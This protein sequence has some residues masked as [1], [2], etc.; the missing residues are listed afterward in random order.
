MR[1]L[2]ARFLAIF[3][4]ALLPVA[5]AAVSVVVS[6]IRH[7][8]EVAVAQVQRWARTV[9]DHQ[10]QL[11]V[12]TELLLTALARNEAVR[13]GGRAECEALLRALRDLHTQYANI[14]V[15]DSTGK[16][17]CSAQPAGYVD[18][19]DRPYYR[20]AMASQ[21]MAGGDYQVGRITRARTL[22]YGYPVTD[23][24]GRV[25]RVVYAAINLDWLSNWTLR[26]SVPPGTALVLADTTG[27]IAYRYPETERYSGMRMDSSVHELLRAGM[28]GG[29]RRARG[30][31]GV[32]R[33][34]ATV[35]VPGP[36]SNFR[37]LVGV[38]ASQAYSLSYQLG[39]R[40]TIFIVILLA[41]VLAIGWMLADQLITKR[42]AVLNAMTQRLAQGDLS[43][44]TGITQGKDELAQLA[45][46]FDSMADALQRSRQDL[47]ELN[48]ELEERVRQRTNEL[49]ALNRE[50]EAFSYSVSHDLRSPLRSMDGF[51]QALLEDYGPQLDD[52]GR[53]YL[54]R[55]RNAAQR[56]GLLIDDLL[57][58]SRV[59]RADLEHTHVDLSKL[60]HEVVQ[61]LRQSEPDRVV[62]VVIAGGMTLDA[63]PGLMHLALQNLIGNAW[64]FTSR[65]PHAR[66][67]VGSTQ[68][69]GQQ[70]FFVRDNGAG[71]DMKYADK[72][73]APFQRL[74]SAN[75]FAGTGIG[76]ATVQRIVMRHGGRVW[77]DAQPDAGATFY[78]TMG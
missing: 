17:I 2:R 44:R 77:A 16:V 78:F 56:M 62:D 8:R 73:F 57:Q 38:P 49:S 53:D 29:E 15:A 34:V 21:R 59:A 55:I 72:L 68:V 23:A 1:G 45:R 71:F 47:A 24:S 5:V 27:L 74:H 43:A 36:Q 41:G 52:T 50:L 60:S 37:L 51:S 6:T 10:E 64:K 30:V 66:I 3:L 75:E 28:P 46:S 35:T 7:E 32:E 26:T 25:R 39:R 70:A 22:N 54:Q 58:L 12:T 69:D 9:A 61:E 65:K 33:F 4:L 42:V 20:G 13:S 19:S 14:G 48:E 63:D 67:E 18:I 31:D 76:L 40:A 11:V